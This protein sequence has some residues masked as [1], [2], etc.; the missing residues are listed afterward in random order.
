MNSEK[1]ADVVY[2]WPLNR[3]F[4]CMY[5]QALF[6]ATKCL[7]SYWLTF[8]S[9][10]KGNFCYLTV[11]IWLTKKQVK[12]VRNLVSLPYLSNNFTFSQMLKKTSSQPTHTSYRKVSWS[13]VW[14]E[15]FQ[16]MLILGLLGMQARLWT[17]G[18][19]DVSTPNFGSHLNRIPT[20]RYVVGKH[21]NQWIN[22]F[23]KIL[24]ESIDSLKFQWIF[25]WLPG[26]LVNL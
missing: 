14:K 9:V 8:S 26:F 13:E 25:K 24:R 23:P 2:G 15:G 17:C 18:R 4:I 1:W 20:S 19:G 7:I 12:I 16:L 5:W 6:K 3:F 10:M 21:S 11:N 22:R